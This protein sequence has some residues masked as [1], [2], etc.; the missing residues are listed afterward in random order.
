LAWSSNDTIFNQRLTTNSFASPGK[1]KFFGDYIG[2]DAHD[3]FVVP[4]WTEYHGDLQLFTLPSKRHELKA[5]SAHFLPI[6]SEIKN[7]EL[8]IHYKNGLGGAVQLTNKKCLIFKSHKTIKIK[9]SQEK[10]GTYVLP[11]KTS[12]NLKI[13][14]DAFVPNTNYKE[15]TKYSFQ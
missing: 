2:V 5:T 4:L 11:L 3:N 9:E 10:S 7:K 6:Y 13:T 1:A 12:K 15:E 8:L 14:V